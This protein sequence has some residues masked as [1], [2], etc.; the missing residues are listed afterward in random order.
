MDALEGL[1]DPPQEASSAFSGLGLLNTASDDVLALSD[2]G[3]FL[4][5]APVESPV[6]AAL[7][8]ASGGDADEG[9]ACRLVGRFSPV[10]GSFRICEG[11][12]KISF[13]SSK[14]LPRQ[15]A[16]S[17]EIPTRAVLACTS[18]GSVLS[19]GVQGMAGRG[20]A[21]E[22]NSAADCFEAAGALAQAG[23]MDDDVLSD[24]EEQDDIGME[25]I[26]CAV[27]DEVRRSHPA[28]RK[29]LLTYLCEMFKMFLGSPTIA[30]PPQNKI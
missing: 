18:E 27:L 2:G 13:E 24:S 14:H 3:G 28:P 6:A 4:S 12:R 11:G 15:L 5:P 8:G 20:I 17:L 7:D 1:L 29:N 21:F 9:T 26:A 25:G 23:L 30:R 16:V 22:Y 19:L 10:S